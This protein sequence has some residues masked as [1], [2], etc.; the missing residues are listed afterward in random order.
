M[1]AKEKARH[2]DTKEMIRRALQIAITWEQQLMDAT[3]CG[4][5][6]EGYRLAKL[7]RDA[8][9]RIL[10]RRYPVQAKPPPMRRVHVFVE[11]RGRR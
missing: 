7:A 5:D 10:R 8:Y 1:D 11:G 3:S 2:G 4:R 6:P 9:V